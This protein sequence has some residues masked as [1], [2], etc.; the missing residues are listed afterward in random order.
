MSLSKV[1][2]LVRRTSGRLLAALRDGPVSL[3]QISID[4]GL[5]LPTLHRAIE[6]IR[7]AA[8]DVECL[9]DWGHSGT[10]RH[11]TRPPRTY[12]LGAGALVAV[13]AIESMTLRQISRTEHGAMAYG[14]A[15]EARAA[16]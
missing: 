7:A 6:C 4:W 3:D 11:S 15:L 10:G 14:A 12:Q 1:S 5:S 8:I 16:G 2:P 13:L 9:R